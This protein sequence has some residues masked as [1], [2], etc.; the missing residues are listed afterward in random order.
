MPHPEN[1][2][3]PYFCC[4][5]LT[6]IKDTLKATFTCEMVCLEISEFKFKV[7]IRYIIL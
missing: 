2:S 5:T 3:M 7:L 1:I 4:L 6:W